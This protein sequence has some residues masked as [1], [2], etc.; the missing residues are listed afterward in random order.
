MPGLE[1]HLFRKPAEL[2]MQQLEE[3]ET[4]L[5]VSAAGDN[6]WERI[7]H[8]PLFTE[9]FVVFAGTTHPFG[10][11]DTI[12]LGELEGQRLVTRP[13]CEHADTF[14]AA[15]DKRRIS[16][17]GCHELSDETDLGAMVGE[18][19][20][21]GIAPRST[22]TPNSVVAIPINDADLQR[23]VSLFAVSGRRYSSAASG[24]IRLLRAADWSGYEHRAS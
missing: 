4:E 24:F 7:D 15:L 21:I 12:G 11:K 8:W 9:D 2:A 17:E 14:S 10:D 1:L 13:Y 5:C 18:G 20:G 6:T 23:T 16:A 22:S 3:G 19:L